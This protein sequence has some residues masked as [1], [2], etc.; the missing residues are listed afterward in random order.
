MTPVRRRLEILQDYRATTG[1]QSRALSGQHHAG[2]LGRTGSP[3]RTPNLLS[4]RTYRS[5][6]LLDLALERLGLILPCDSLPR[7]HRGL[8]APRDRSCDPGTF[9]RAV[10]AM[11]EALTD[12]DSARITRRNGHGR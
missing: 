10:P 1:C 9:R 12:D 3:Q 6:V 11:R 4:E 5:D 2:P 8:P 7:R